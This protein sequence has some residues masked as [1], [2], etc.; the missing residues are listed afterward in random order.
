MAVTIQRR[1]ILLARNEHP[2]FHGSSVEVASSDDLPVA[3][4]EGK[5]SA[6]VTPTP[7]FPQRAVGLLT[8]SA[9]AGMGRVNS[10]VHHADDYPL[11]SACRAPHCRPDP[12]WQVEVIWGVD[13]ILVNLVALLDA[14]NFGILGETQSLSKQAITG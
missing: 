1:C 5:P 12:L 3:R 10:C 4:A 2:S 14:G 8:T 7:V 9:K 13:S 11:P 6:V